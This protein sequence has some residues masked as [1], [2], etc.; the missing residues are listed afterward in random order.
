MPNYKK[1]ILIYPYNIDVTPYVAHRSLF[2]DKIVS[3]L[4]SPSGFGLTGRDAGYADSRGH[5]KHR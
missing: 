4:V 5:P 3:S 1:R 2:T